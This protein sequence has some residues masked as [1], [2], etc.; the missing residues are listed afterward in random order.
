MIKYNKYLLK[1]YGKI[2]R[3]N[4]KNNRDNKSIHIILPQV[5][6]VLILTIKWKNHLWKELKCLNSYL[7]NFNISFPLLFNNTQDFLHNNIR[8]FYIHLVILIQHNII[9]SNKGNKDR[10][11]KQIL[12]IPQKYLVLPFQCKIKTN[13]SNLK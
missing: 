4:L 13:K 3:R 12:Y 5:N 1:K 2:W 6:T 10:H 8:D 11:H 9:N 7:V